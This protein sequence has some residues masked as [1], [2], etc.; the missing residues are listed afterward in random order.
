MVDISGLPE[1]SQKIMMRH[2][3]IDRDHSNAY[4]VWKDIGSPQNPTP[5]Q[6]AKLKAAGQLQ[7][8]GSPQFVESKLGTM[9]LEFTLPR[10]GVS[11]VELSW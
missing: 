2:Y 5:E 11:L 8:L 7:L 1:Q 9:T 10:Q 6:Y 4:T 3:R